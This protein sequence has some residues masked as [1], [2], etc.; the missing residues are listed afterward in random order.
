MRHSVGLKNAYSRCVKVAFDS[1]TLNPAIERLDFAELSAIL[2]A[3]P[4]IQYFNILA[5]RLGDMM[6]DDSMNKPAITIVQLLEKL[7]SDKVSASN[8]SVLISKINEHLLV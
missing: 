2:I 7:T 8:Y 1:P 4:N 6:F 5:V 3:T